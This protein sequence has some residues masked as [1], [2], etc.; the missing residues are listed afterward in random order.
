MRKTKRKRMNLTVVIQ[1][2]FLATV[3]AFVSIPLIFTIQKSLEVKGLENYAIVWQRNSMIRNF[4]NSAIVSVLTIIVVLTCVILAAYTLSKLHFP[5]KNVI[6]L[7]FLSGLMI[8]GASILF[9]TF[10]IVK[11]MGLIDNYLGLVGPY[12]AVQIPFNL[13]IMKNYYDTIPNEILESSHIDGCNS[14]STLLHIILPLSAPALSVIILWTFL[15]VWN[16]FMYAFTFIEKSEMRTLTS[17]PSKFTGLHSSNYELVFA[18]LVIIQLPII[19]LYLVTQNKL[20]EG[21]VSGS[22]KG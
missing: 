6:F 4:M 17:L 15:G 1:N 3:A 9:P 16:E 20:Q 5:F 19:F 14:F 12:A 21:L 11:G 2:L 10:Q 8:P 13:V 7:M 22:L 18:A